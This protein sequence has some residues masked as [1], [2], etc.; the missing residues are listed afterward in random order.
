MRTVYRNRD[1]LRGV[2][3]SVG[4]ATAH[5]A[6]AN[7]RL[8]FE[9]VLAPAATWHA[10]LLYEL[11]DGDA[12]SARRHCL[13]LAGERSRHAAAQHAWQEAVL[14]IRT[15]NEEFYRFYHQAMRRH[16]GAAPADRGHGPLAFVPAAGLPWFVALF[17]R[18]SLIVSLQNAL[19]YPEFAR[20]A[21]DVL[22]RCRPRS[23]TTT[24]TPSPARSCTNCA[25]ANWR[26]SS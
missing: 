8:S 2:S 21:L 17:G 20:G 5:A 26:I 13:R 1:F 16:G 9:V 7:G 19:V 18:D 4:E 6:Y 25:A 14:K 23:A 12:I 22:G 3:V 11:F 15:S 10:C 24:A